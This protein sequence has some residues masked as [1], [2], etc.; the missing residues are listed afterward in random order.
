MMC[1]QADFTKISY[2]RNHGGDSGEI[3]VLVTLGLMSNLPRADHGARL[4]DDSSPG[5]PKRSCIS[6]GLANSPS[7][8]RECR[9]LSKFIVS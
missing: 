3:V 5:V 2:L 7:T 9:T 1:P 8:N 4:A 6:V